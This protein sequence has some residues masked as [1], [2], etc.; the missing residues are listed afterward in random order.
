MD[1]NDII[2]EK[3]KY[4]FRIL[5]FEY[6]TKHAFCD[7]MCLKTANAEELLLLKEKILQNIMIQREYYNFSY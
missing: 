5:L 7:I 2:I 3:F 1:N 4:L 6:Y